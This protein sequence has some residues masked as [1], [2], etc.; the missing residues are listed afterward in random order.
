MSS[1]MTLSPA[2]GSALSGIHTGLQNLRGAAAEI[3]GTAVD[4]VGRDP[5]RPL[6]EQR[7]Q[8]RQVEAS[9]EV[10]ETEQRMLGTLIDMKV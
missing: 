2:S 4:P 7:I 5:A 1:P 10:L 9:V 6:V 8:A 3:A